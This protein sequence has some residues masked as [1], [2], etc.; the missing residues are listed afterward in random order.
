M[1][2]CLKFLLIGVGVLVA[3]IVIVSIVGGRTSSDSTTTTAPPNN[4][5]VSHPNYGHATMFDNIDTCEGDVP[6]H[7]VI[8]GTECRKES[9]SITS[10]CGV[11][12][13]TYY[14]LI[15]DGAIGYINVKW[16]K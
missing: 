6:S 4:V 8:N 14:K 13:G 2:G 16:V 7:D 9:G 10:P 1:K 5:I 12:Y 3:I 11:E 15:C